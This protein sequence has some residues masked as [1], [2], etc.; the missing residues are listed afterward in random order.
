MKNFNFKT[1][2]DP[3]TVKKDAM[4]GKRLPDDFNLNEGS[5]MGG[6]IGKGEAAI[7]KASA[8]AAAKAFG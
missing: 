5:P 3:N 7:R 8:A 2:R 6:A 4:L 1:N